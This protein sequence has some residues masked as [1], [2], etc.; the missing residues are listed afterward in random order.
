[1]WNMEQSRYK[2]VAF[3]LFL[4]V[5][6]GYTPVTLVAYFLS[7]AW[8][9]SVNSFMYC[10]SKQK[11]LLII[12]V[13]SIGFGLI[14][15][16]FFS[17]IPSMAD[18]RVWAGFFFFY[19]FSLFLKDKDMVLREICNFVKILFYLDF[20]T[21]I[22][23]ILGFNLPWAQVPM[24]RPGELFPRL[25]G[26]KN[27]A[28]FSG[29]ISLLYSVVLLFENLK[30]TKG[31]IFFF[32]MLSLNLLFAGS[33]RFFVILFLLLVVK[34]FKL[35]EKRFN[36][37]IAF[38]LMVFLVVVLTILTQDISG[39]NNIR[40]KLWKSAV[41]RVF[42]ANNCIGQGFFIPKV[43]EGITGFIKLQQA[44]VTESTILQWGVCFGY[45]VMLLLVLFF[46]RILAKILNYHT[47]TLG[48]GFIL[49]ELSL[50]FFGGGIGNILNIS[51]LSLSIASINNHDIYNNPDV[52]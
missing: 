8:A 20:I 30:I 1:M 34:Y 25:P 36:V 33:Y 45:I 42:D 29:Y 41:S 32:C 21:N 14:N 6:V 2:L 15:F 18:I 28:L 11:M 38:I 27:S 44:G 39:S 16:S 51:L 10:L 19:L 48:V 26:V 40:L 12:F 9:S 5:L 24:T 23:L 37:L 7:V 46:I 13:L 4:L 52:Q 47:F 22:L 3:S 35:F 50:W 43:S 17:I 31:N 49:I